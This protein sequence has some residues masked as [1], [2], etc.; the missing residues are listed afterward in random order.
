MRRGS[1]NR[2][3]MSGVLV[4]ASVLLVAAVGA[5]QARAANGFHPQIASLSHSG[6]QYACGDAVDSQ[7][8]LYV[9]DYEEAKVHVY[10]AA[11][12][13]EFSASEEITSFETT[14]NGESPCS[15]AVDASGTVYVN[16]WH[17]DVVKYAPS[18]YPPTATTTYSPAG[19][20]VPA[21]HHATAVAVDPETQDAYVAEPPQNEQQEI[22][23]SSGFAEG[24]KF[25][26]GFE[27]QE[28]AEIEYTLV[29]PTLRSRILAALE[30]K[31][32][33]NFNATGFVKVIFEGVYEHL[34]VPQM[35]C[36][37]VSG[38]GTCP[39]STKAVGSQS[40]VS[41]FQSNGTPI[42]TTIGEGVVPGAEYFGV[43]VFGETGNVY[44]TD[45]AHEKAYILN[46]AGT[47]IE[48]EIDGSTSQEGAFSGMVEPYLAVDQSN[49]NMLVSDIPGHGVV[50]E[51]T[52]DGAFVTQ[53]SHE[54]EPLEEAEPSDIAVDNGSSSHQ[55]GTVYVTSAGGKVY[56]Y[57]PLPGGRPR[58]SLAVEKKGQG[59]GSVTSAPAGLE[60]G[61]TCEAEFEE[62]KTVTLTAT[63]AEGSVFTEWGPGCEAQT[64]APSGGECTLKIE[65]H[66]K[67]TAI[68]WA[69][70]VVSGEEAAK[71][72]SST[73]E[74]KA[75][76]NPKGKV[77]T[78]QFQ[79]ITL[80]AYE[81]NLE[82]AKDGFSG[83]AVAPASPE[84]IGAGVSATPV[85]MGLTG[86]TPAT[87]YRFRV[88][89]ANEIGTTEGELL[90]GEEVART[91]GTYP[92]PEVI[93]AG[94]CPENETLR[95]GP[96]AHLP[97]CRAYE[98]ASPVDKNGGNV[99][100]TEQSV[101]AAARGAGVTF[102][103]L[104]GVPGGE[105]S[106]EFPTYLSSRQG[107]GADAHWST[108]G[109]LPSAVAGEEGQVLGWTP[110]LDEVFDSAG[111]AG[112]GTALL[113]RSSDG[114]GLSE[115]APYALSGPRFF[116]VAAPSNTTKVFF[117]ADGEPGGMAI[118]SP[119]VP[120]GNVNLYATDRGA[121]GVVQ[122]VGR[123]PDG[124][125]PSGGSVASGQG[126]A[127]VQDSRAVSTGGK[128][129]YFTAKRPGE[130][131]RQLYRRLNPTAPETS[132]RDGEGNCVP[133][134][135]LACTVLVSKSEKDNGEGAEKHDA[136]GT[137]P[138]EFQAASAD[139]SVAYF[140]SSEKLTD[141]A[142]TGPEPK[143]RAIAQANL[144]GSG[145]NLDYLPTGARDVKV[146]GEY[147]YWTDPRGGNEEEGTI[148][149]AKI[150]TTEAEDIEPEYINGLY[151][152]RSVALDTEHIYW[153]E[154]RNKGVEEGTIGRAKIGV[155][156]A[157][158]INR[159]FIVE[160]SDPDGIAVDANHL[161]WANVNLKE[162]GGGFL[163]CMGRAE[164]SGGT[165][166]NITQRFIQGFVQGDV[167]INE[168]DTKVYY[169]RPNP[170][171]AA[172]GFIRRSNIDGSNDSTWPGDVT[173]DNDEEAPVI[174]VDGSHLYWTNFTENEIGRSDL[175]GT[176]ASREQGFIEEAGHPRGLT[177][178]GSHLYWSA[179]Q[180]V[181]K[182]PGNDLYRY[183]A[184]ADSEGN[185]L[186]DI[187][188]DSSPSDKDGVE[189]QGVLGV[190]EDGA[191]VYYAANGVPDNLAISSNAEGEEAEPGNC[192]TA[193]VTGICNLYAWHDGQATFVAH[194]RLNG[195]V[196]EGDSVDWAVTSGG[197]KLQRTSR[198]TPD[199]RTLLFRSTGQLSGYDNNG[200][201]ELYLYRVGDA[202]PI[203]VSCNPS[204]ASPTSGVSLSRVRNPNEGARI[205]A[206]TL[207]RNLSL[208]GKRVF[209]ESTDPLVPEDTNGEKGCQH[210]GGQ[211]QD[212]PACVDV[213][214]WEAEGEGSC[215]SEEDNGG[216]LY[217][218]STGKGSDPALL[219]D[220]NEDGSDV[221]IFT[222]DRLVGQDKDSLFDAYDVREGGGLVSQGGEA[223]PCDGDTC[224]PPATPPPAAIPPGSAGFSGPAS[225]RPSR[226]HH[227]SKHKKHKHHKRHGKGKRGSGAGHEGT[228][229]TGRAGR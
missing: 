206:A 223:A 123:L 20:I 48:A 41:S 214:E 25:K 184:I 1:G 211:S 191:Y 162:E 89:A 126:G 49:G 6:L 112:L 101:R 185:H 196:R 127:Y 29:A 87:T 149:R 30:A 53:I 17:A 217:L 13:A 139:G 160:A 129:V 76:V 167:A 158:G 124:S 181:V 207:T 147:I 133:N 9:A 194:L 193:K 50:D 146:W 132:Q 109:V 210:V 108:Q 107:E 115:V 58:F 199:G 173:I 142:R 96:S 143:A 106:Q 55:Q 40:H 24:D 198:V 141:D 116:F 51:F 180:A 113:S 69:R 37:V 3:Q 72:T 64:Q 68:F 15:I 54:P 66:T 93:E 103:S 85:S 19:T 165:P 88:V 86:L 31:F 174:A 200:K 190:S 12:N 82:A 52:E 23:F 134:E 95:T 150:G 227:K 166:T 153:T 171:A 84:G 216:C 212:Y 100:G 152:P 151:D 131:D 135:T 224:K 178:D 195:S 35:S 221:F 81:A 121:S 67:V 91:F 201:P 97:D 202:G 213:Y 110:D 138:D 215:K 182:N 209:F 177:V 14:G 39:I 70:P 94:E 65:G 2:G 119:A 203:C 219:G 168:A 74:L 32:G 172:N 26:L 104:A 218:L 111:K 11:G 36:A 90:T 18:A 21:G 189:V 144:D 62:G 92:P 204:G 176:A 47:A 102:E 156:E 117:E 33:S 45:V 122:L 163:G 169:S 78:Y 38:S 57:G 59:S 161:Y 16:G 186:T 208:N 125:V 71:V 137:A 61:A 187:A 73:A 128:S 28:T 98:Q 10:A 222:P 226:R 114:G 155:T 197:G 183:H 148:G 220:A 118:G 7:G 145:A 188:P 225:P 164:I 159:E 60:C 154:A 83:A 80:A 34:D 8:D 99:G 56:A 5:Q 4:I 27:G 46:P 157:E 192:D 63:P 229:A 43:D 79:Y 205:P 22:A 75:L 140:T 105:G 170:L 77:T 44:V 42:S 175:D 228:K 120:A 136:A 179:N 130:L